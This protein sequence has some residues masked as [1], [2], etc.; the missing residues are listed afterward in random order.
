M[1][2]LVVLT[3]ALL[4]LA[5]RA[6]L[7]SPGELAKPHH[8]LEGLSNCTQCHPEGGKLSQETCLSCH[9]ELKGRVSRGFGF[10]GHIP[11]AERECETCHKEHQGREFQLI[12]W[13]PAGQKGFAHARTGWPLKGKHEP[14]ECAKCHQP[15]LIKVPVIQQ[16]LEK[17]PTRKTWLGLKT[18]CQDC[19]FDE[20]RGQLEGDCDYCHRE[21][22]WKPA[23]GFNHDETSYAL[24]G[25]HKKVKCEKCHP[26]TSEA[27]KDVFPPPRAETF[28]R[29]SKIDHDSCTD[30]H[31]DAH[32]GRFGPRCA[33]CHTVEGWKLIRNAAQERGFHDKTRFP[34]KGEHLDVACAA[35]HGPFPGQPARFK[36]LPFATCTACHVDAHEGQ[37]QPPAGQKAPDCDACH[38]VDGFNTPRFG[39][40]QHDRTRFPLE[41]AHRVVGCAVCHEHTTQVL[42]KVPAAVRAEVKRRR[43]H[44][45]FSPALF[46]FTKP[47]DACDSCHKDVHAGQFEGREKGCAGCHQVGSFHELKF[48]HDRDSKFPLTGKHRQVECVKCHAPD[49]RGEPMVYRPIHPAC[50]TCHVDNHAGQFEPK[51]CDDCHV[52]EDFKKVKFEHA[53]PNTRFTLEGKHEK[54]ECLK[55]HPRVSVGGKVAV[56]RFKGVPQACEGC[57]S[58]FHQG[59]F[60]GFEP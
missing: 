20:H 19:H 4:P 55:C 54:V 48:S 6:D 2:R 50:D 21:A 1:T 43:L 32:D 11:T 18:R 16:M 41:G 28:A 59:A 26:T 58:D 5:A 51:A 44:E 30:C 7:F 8:A 57:H 46:D 33:S 45:L 39:L 47:L 14:V 22:D 9:T 38:A 49:R 25:Q 35:C 24:K 12:T 60:K 42:E 40:Q 3:L 31:K 34:L 27:R 56:Q 23:P 36:G 37:L 17:Q 15:R 10:H 29:F 13:G 52:T 53:P